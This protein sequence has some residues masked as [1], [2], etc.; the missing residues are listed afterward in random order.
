[1]LLIVIDCSTNWALVLLSAVWQRKL[2]YIFVVER[3]DIHIYLFIYKWNNCRIIYTVYERSFSTL[4]LLYSRWHSLHIYIYTY[5]SSQGYL[6]CITVV[7]FSH[8]N[9]NHYWNVVLCVWVL[10]CYIHNW[11][12]LLL[13]SLL[14]KSF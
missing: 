12:S 10:M 14:S 9:W 5:T 4:F 7:T 8:C 6:I 2:H 11:K 13:S 1:V 3:K